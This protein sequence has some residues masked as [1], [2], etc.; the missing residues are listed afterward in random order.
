TDVDDYKS[1]ANQDWV[2]A[3]ASELANM[4]FDLDNDW[5]SKLPEN[6]F[7]KEYGF[8]DDKL[9]YIN[10]NNELVSADGRRVDEQGRY[11][12]ED[13][14]YEDIDGNPVDEDG[15]PLET[16]TP[17]TRGG[18]PVEKKETL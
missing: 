14:G 8:I 13:G 18:V 4:V 12:S 5:E 10:E 2:V 9:R 17:F 1:R 16:F 3:A 6:E 15:N 7:L 11:L